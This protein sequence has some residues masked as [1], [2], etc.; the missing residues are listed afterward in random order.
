MNKQMVVIKGSS[1]N[2]DTLT[3]KVTN[4]EGILFEHKYYYGYDISFCK[5]F[6]TEDKPLDNELVQAK[7]KEYS[8]KIEDIQYE[9]GI[10]IFKEGL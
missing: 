1:I 4:E 5:V 2:A 3:I 10:N 8:I 9:E 7:A 6:A